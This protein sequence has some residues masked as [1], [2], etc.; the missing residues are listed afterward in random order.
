MKVVEGM[1]GGGGFRRFSRASRLVEKG[2]TRRFAE[3][4][5]LR[6][7]QETSPIVHPF[8]DSQCLDQGGCVGDRY[9]G[10]QVRRACSA[11]LFACSK[12][13]VA[14]SEGD[15]LGLTATRSNLD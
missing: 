8:P 11:L 4:P 10:I 3:N 14:S 1:G 2:T 7:T 9:G 12:F 6:T 15:G 13:R 5:R